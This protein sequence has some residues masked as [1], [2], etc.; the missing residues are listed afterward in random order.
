MPRPA[1]GQ[2]APIKPVASTGSSRYLTVNERI[3]IADRL[4]EKASLRAIATELGRTPSTI[5][6]EVRRKPPL[7][8]HSVS[9][10]RC[11]GKG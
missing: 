8:L 10:I 3:H 9:A 4:R 1:I 5:S 11:A 2:P 7:R 6:R